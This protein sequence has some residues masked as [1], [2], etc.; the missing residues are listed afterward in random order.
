MLLSCG[1]RIS[2]AAF[3]SSGAR[4]TRAHSLRTEFL[5]RLLVAELIAT[6]IHRPGAVVHDDDA[7][8]H[9]IDIVNPQALLRAVT[10]RVQERA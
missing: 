5:P 6:E 10:A 3:A 2:F 7:P 1:G 9:Q 8:A 4:H